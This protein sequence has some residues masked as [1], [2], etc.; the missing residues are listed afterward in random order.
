[1]LRHRGRLI[2]GGWRTSGVRH[3]LVGT[4]DWGWQQLGEV[5]N[6]DERHRVWRCVRLYSLGFSHG[7][8]DTFRR[9]LVAHNEMIWIGSLRGL[10]KVAPHFREP[11]LGCRVRAGCR[12]IAHR[13]EHHHDRRCS[14]GKQKKRR[15]EG[16]GTSRCHASLIKGTRRAGALRRSG[17]VRDRV[18]EHSR[19][20]QELAGISVE[21][22]VVPLLHILRQPAL[23]DDEIAQLPLEG[24]QIDASNGGVREDHFS[25]C[26]D[27]RRRAPTTLPVRAG[28]QVS[29][30]DRRPLAKLADFGPHTGFK[31]VIVGG[32]PQYFT[33]QGAM[34]FCN[35]R[36]SREQRCELSL[37]HHRHLHPGRSLRG[38]LAGIGHRRVCLCLGG[39][40]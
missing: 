29:C 20:H 7:G 11:F 27:P 19:T 3:R 34:I 32:K 15:R 12:P 2:G 18:K 23:I 8:H 5:I 4:D 33:R 38:R 10:Q 25:P 17:R 37:R 35:G 28:E 13:H 24:V 21:T 16:A 31:G 14:D 22:S 30:L 39:V 9:L 6:L 40:G 36:K 1:M 26:G